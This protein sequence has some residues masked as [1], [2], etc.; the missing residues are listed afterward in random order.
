MDKLTQIFLYAD[1][2]TDFDWRQIIPLAPMI[3]FEDG[4]VLILIPLY[5]H[6]SNPIFNF[7]RLRH[8]SNLNSFWSVF[9]KLPLAPPRTR[10]ELR[11]GLR[12]AFCSRNAR[13]LAWKVQI[14]G[15]CKSDT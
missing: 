2:S 9:Y 13:I 8:Y 10:V 7:P 4:P 5:V 6:P 1:I 3:L 15:V 14:F 11:G 12:T